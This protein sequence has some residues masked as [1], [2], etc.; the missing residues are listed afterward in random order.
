MIE[1]WIRLKCVWCTQSSESKA[2][3]V[4]VKKSIF[5]QPALSVAAK[6]GNRNSIDDEFRTQKRIFLFRIPIARVVCV[7]VCWFL[8]SVWVHTDVWRHCKYYISRHIELSDDDDIDRRAR[9]QI[10]SP[11]RPSIWQSA[12]FILHWATCRSR[13]H[14]P[15]SHAVVVKK[16]M[17]IQQRPT[18]WQISPNTNVPIIHI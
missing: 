17:M 3:I 12:M 8:D 2:I 14:Q 10:Q 6:C 5:T 1:I 7:W 11:A 4:V 13:T 16:K 9:S 15:T 18:R